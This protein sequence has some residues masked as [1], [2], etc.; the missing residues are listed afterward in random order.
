M[1]RSMDEVGG[2]SVIMLV[3]AIAAVNCAGMVRNGSSY[4]G[5]P[6]KEGGMLDRMDG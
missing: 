5:I 6:T 3:S 2:G 4:I 1:A